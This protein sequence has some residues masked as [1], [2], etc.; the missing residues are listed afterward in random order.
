MF[1]LKQ[2]H[3]SDTCV[4]HTFQN[5]NRNCPAYFP[6]QDFQ[7]SKDGDE[8]EFDVPLKMNWLVFLGGITL[9]Q[10][11]CSLETKFIYTGKNY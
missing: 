6:F 10:K 4:L 1:C 8:D 9:E 3:R 11:I 7:D 5:F 2:N